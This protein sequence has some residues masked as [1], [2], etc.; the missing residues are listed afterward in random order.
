ML[1]YHPHYLSK[2]YMKINLQL[3]KDHLTNIF[4]YINDSLEKEY[5]QTKIPSKIKILYF[6]E[7]LD[8][9]ITMIYY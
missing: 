2:S 1:Q 8:I 6:F 4:E 9:Y 7:D 3:F 5:Y